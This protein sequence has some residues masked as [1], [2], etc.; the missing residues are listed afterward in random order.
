M[1]IPSNPLRFSVF[2]R[3]HEHFESMNDYVCFYRDKVKD[4]TWYHG[5][6]GDPV[7]SNLT[8]EFFNLND[9]LLF[10]LTHG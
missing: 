6:V 7:G 1:T 9:A 3:D 5:F 8:I 10:K 2:V 4:Y